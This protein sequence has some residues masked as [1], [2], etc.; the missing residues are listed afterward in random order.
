M[1][2]EKVCAHFARTPQPIMAANY[3][4]PVLIQLSFF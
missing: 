4:T 3:A 1:F 2:G